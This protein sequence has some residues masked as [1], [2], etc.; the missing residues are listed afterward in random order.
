VQTYQRWRSQ[1]KAMRPEDVVR[2][3]ASEKERRIA[4][5]PGADGACAV[6]WRRLAVV[7]RHPYVPALVTSTRL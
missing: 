1:F 4:D 2:L 5:R 6:S 7:H 3:K